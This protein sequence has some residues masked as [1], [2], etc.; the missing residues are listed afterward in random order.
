[1]TQLSGWVLAAAA[2]LTGPA[3]WSTL[4]TGTMPLDVALTRFLIATAACWVAV[5]VLAEV[6][7]STETVQMHTDEP[8]ANEH[9]A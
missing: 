8:N 2:V 4:V 3:L 9:D 1:M 5:S 6:W 7:P